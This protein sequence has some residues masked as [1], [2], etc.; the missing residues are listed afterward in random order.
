MEKMSNNNVEIPMDVY[1]SKEEILV[2][3]P[4][5]GVDKS[6]IE[7]ILENTSIKVKWKRNQPKIKD[8]MV[9]AKQECYWWDF[10]KTI[11]LPQN[12]YFEKIH[13]KLTSDNILL[14]VV[15]KVIIPDKVKL[16][17]QFN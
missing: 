16:D 2:M 4:L 7:V 8:N 9:I 12:V 6:S 10:G 15:P 11:N 13:T 1:E 14:I 3:M 5:W 17:I